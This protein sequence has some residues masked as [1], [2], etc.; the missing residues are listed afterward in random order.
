MKKLISIILAICM[1]IQPVVGFAQ[2]DYGE[3]GF[4]D[5][6]GHWA[7]DTIEKY[8]HKGMV[9]GY[10]NNTFMPDAKMKRSEMAAFINRYFGFSEEALENY[11]D[12]EESDW[13]FSET[14]K[15]KYYGY[16][17][18]MQARPQEATSRED[19]VRTL[20]LIIDLDEQESLGEV[21][22]FGDLENLKEEDKEN[23]E[24]FS[25][26][27]YIEGYGDGSF[28]PS[29]AVSRAE[30]LT[31]MERVL[32][33]IVMIQEDADNIPFGAAKVTIINPGIIIK[34]KTIN[35]SIYI[36]AGAK[37]KT[38]IKDTTVTGQIEVAG[39]EII[40]DGVTAEK[41]VVTKAKETP[42]VSVRGSNIEELDIKAKAE[43]S[44]SQGTEIQRAETNA[45]TAIGMEEGSTI[46]S[47][48]A[49]Q[50]TDITG[51]GKIT[52]TY[53]KTDQ[54]TME[55]SSGY[56][57]VYSACKVLVGDRTITKSND[58]H[59]TSSAAQ[60][61]IVLEDGTAEHPYLIE[62]IDDLAKIG[63]TDEWA[64]D[65]SYKLMNDLD[66]NVE[67][68]Y[69][70]DSVNYVNGKFTSGEGWETIGSFTDE[71]NNNPFMGT[72]DG[73]G[74]TISHLFINRNRD[75]QGLFGYADGAE[76]KNLGMLDANISGNQYVGGIVGLAAGTSVNSISIT[77]CYSTGNIT[78]N[79]CVGGIVGFAYIGRISTCYATGAVRA[80][81]SEAVDV[82]GI[83][84]GARGSTISACYVTGDISGEDGVGGVVGFVDSTTIY[85]SYAI[86]DIS[87]GH[88]AGGV[89]GRMYDS[90]LSA[91]Y[92]TGDVSG[93]INVYGGVGGI[94]GEVHNSTISSC[95]AFNESV[96]R[97][98]DVNRVVGTNYGCTLSNNHANANMLVNGTMELS[99]EATTLSGADIE[100]MTSI[101]VEP[102]S[103]WDFESTWEMK[104]GAC[105]PTLI[106]LGNDDAIPPQWSSSPSAVEGIENGQ[107]NLSASI[108]ET[109]T[110]YYAVVTSGSA[111]L[112]KESI[113]YGSGHVST[114][115]AASFNSFAITGLTAG[116]SY[117]I[118]IV[119]EDIVGNNGSVES[120]LGVQAKPIDYGNGTEANPYKILKI[121]DL[122]RIGTDTLDVNGETWGLGESYILMNNLDFDS[123]SS[124]VSDS[125]HFGNQTFTSGTGWR[126]IGTEGAE[127]TGTF[128]GNG[129]TIS[130]LFI[131]KDTDYAGL[132]G[133]VSGS[134]IRGTG[135]L[136]VDIASGYYSGGMAGYVESSTL[137][138]CYVTGA[139]SVIRGNYGGGI[140]GEV[141]NGEIAGCH[142]T[143]TVSGV[144][145]CVGGIAGQVINACTISNSYATGAV[146][147][148]GENVGGIAGS[149]DVNST[150]SSCL[151][152]NESVTGSANVNRVIG[153]Y[154]S[155][156]ISNNYANSGLLVAEMTSN[157]AG[158]DTVNG[159][160]IA[161]MTST[162]A[163]PLS[164][165]DFNAEI[166]GDGD[167]DGDNAY[168]K[169]ESM[170]DT[171]G[172][173]YTRDRPVL[174]VEPDGDGEYEKLG[175]DDGRI[176]WMHVD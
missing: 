144:G 46:G 96:T 52:R 32:G 127:F 65:K 61:A 15:A 14:A 47:L 38:T 83:V 89:V 16:I 85:D 122:A 169:I 139:V 54:M 100:G 116:E 131:N 79:N 63:T 45:E 118:Y 33:Y 111:A 72:F 11:E 167:S 134:T 110:V 13:F 5:I 133:V 101:G 93:T 31:I 80:T 95:S 12:V 30:I 120:I 35:G 149:L 108:S 1:L 115:S 98:T 99:L 132:F 77:D 57:R 78:G 94:V 62:T 168:W 145:E 48:T 36:T 147:G 82:G 140:A 69:E 155:G 106:G 158:A 109:G 157:L 84:G 124:Y 103:S 114:G 70:S 130:N 121:E 56:I 148:S 71:D 53:V 123:A 3:E 160:N 113:K 44:L 73:N 152:F 25:S 27:G 29:D 107:I 176:S 39:G 97:S 150:I 64:M 154:V 23:I 104:S 76:I 162:G 42:K 9:K 21:K 119:S 19:L 86:G 60:S 172:T 153:L 74:N 173:V 112:T 175:S 166:D 88:N 41:V 91:C 126:P 37:G 135:L 58:D 171:M 24:R 20:S 137:T 75:F 4:I 159:A 6:E 67:S 68:S 55:E 151:A 28:R 34:G 43:V 66:F 125:V 50:K 18:E 87:G 40:L 165:W 156:T 136:E 49:S 10:L 174:Y 105:R 129:K 26:L 141:N 146:S 161:S 81:G 143:A 59:N 17:E 51:S 128:D 90:V 117:D 142:V 163:A 22:D 8:H 170:T 138:A 7:S 102:L 92:A 2:T 164:S